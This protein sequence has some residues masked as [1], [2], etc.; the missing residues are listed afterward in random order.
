MDAL[1]NGIQVISTECGIELLQKC[2]FVS[3]EKSLDHFT[4][5]SRNVLLRRC[6][7]FPQDK[8]PNAVLYMHSTEIDLELFRHEWLLRKPIVIMKA[9][10]DDHNW[11]PDSIANDIGRCKEKMV[12]YANANRSTVTK[13]IECLCKGFKSKAGNTYVHCI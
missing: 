4:P 9:D 3:E 7:A 8:R 11:T 13:T 1:F 12:N 2:R 6:E 5:I 10:F